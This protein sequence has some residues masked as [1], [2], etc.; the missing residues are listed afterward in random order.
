MQR[1]KIGVDL[2]KLGLAAPHLPGLNQAHNEV[3]NFVLKEQD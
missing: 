3:I 1:A 2:G